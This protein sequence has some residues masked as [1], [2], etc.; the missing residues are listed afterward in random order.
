MFVYGLQPG[1]RII[2]L[3]EVPSSVVQREQLQD[4]AVFKIELDAPLAYAS[5]QDIEY[6]FSHRRCET[7]SEILNETQPLSLA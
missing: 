5:T 3:Y 1:N 7:L 6:R 4:V 2:H